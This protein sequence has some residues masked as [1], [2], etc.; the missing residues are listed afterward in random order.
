MP[1][2]PQGIIPP[3][4]S[5]LDH[6]MNPELQVLDQQKAVLEQRRRQAKEGKDAASKPTKRQQAQKRAVEVLKS[7]A[8]QQHP[9]H[10]EEDIH[11]MLVFSGSN[12]PPLYVPLDEEE[13][14]SE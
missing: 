7:L 8:H 13:D 11:V 14:P 3:P 10:P 12:E 5:V 2:G 6:I 4:G 1:V 9:A